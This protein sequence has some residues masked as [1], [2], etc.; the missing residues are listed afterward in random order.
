MPFSKFNSPATLQDG[1]QVV[2]LTGPLTRAAGEGLVELHLLVVQ[3]GDD[4]EPAAIA[5]GEGQ[6][7]VDWFGSAA[8]TLG[9]LT[10]GKALAS[11][12]AISIRDNP[13]G[14]ETFSW[15]QEIELTS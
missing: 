4:G 3:F 9:Q 13:P 5:R 2:V 15:S 10:V 6:G 1:G 12:L 14:F 8:A 7:L 11:G